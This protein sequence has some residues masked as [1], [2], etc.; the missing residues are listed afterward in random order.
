MSREKQGYVPISE[1]EE[2]KI[3]RLE[4]LESKADRITDLRSRV[5]TFLKS[6]R[7]RLP[8][9]SPEEGKKYGVRMSMDEIMVAVKGGAS[10]EELFGFDESVTGGN[11]PLSFEGFEAFYF[12]GGSE[13]KISEIEEGLGEQNAFIVDFESI[14]NVH[15]ELEGLLLGEEEDEGKEDHV[16]NFYEMRRNELKD[17]S[18][19]RYKLVSYL[20]YLDR[21]LTRA[22]NDKQKF[23]SIRKIR[24]AYRQGA[25][26]L[27]DLLESP[28]GYVAIMGSR[29][30]Q[31]KE[32]FD[33]GGKI[34]ET[35]YV[36][37]MMEKMTAT[38]KTG[39]P[40]FLYG[41]L[42][43]GKT[44]L[45]R[46]LARKTLSEAHVERWKK[47]NPPPSRENK[48][49]SKE[50]R[51]RL[52][53]QHE[54][55]V[56]SGH[57]TSEASE[58]T[59]TRTIEAKEQVSPE[60]QA[61]EIHLRVAAARTE[62]LGELKGKP[63]ETVKEYMEEWDET[64]KPSLIKALETSFNNPIE[65]GER[66][67]M[68]LEAMHDGRPLVIDE[69]NA[70]P[71]HTLI[72]MNDLLTRRPGDEVNV[73]YLKKPFTVAEGFIVIGTG[74]YKP[75]DGLMYKGRQEM[76]AAFLSRFALMGY[77]YLPQRKD[78]HAMSADLPEE[79]QR[80][81]K[82]ENELFQMLVVR[83]ID[84][85]L[86]FEAPPDVFDQLHRLS[87]VA[88]LLQEIFS[89]TDDGKFKFTDPSNAKSAETDPGLI[90]KENVLSLRH[91][92]PIVQRWKE[93]GFRKPLDDYLFDEYVTRSNARPLEK[94]N[95]YRLLQ[96]KSF[97]M[98]FAYG[99]MPWPGSNG[100]DMDKVLTFSLDHSFY[101]RTE[102]DTKVM[103]ASVELEKHRFTA[104]DIIQEIFGN[105]PERTEISKEFIEGLSPA[106]EEDEVSKEMQLR[107]AKKMA[108]AKA[109]GIGFTERTGMKIDRSTLKKLADGE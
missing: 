102:V 75:E 58:L 87:V 84:K 65:T 38:L 86:S 30:R 9:K 37:M 24:D 17:V 94:F 70:I 51:I 93:E 55:L 78:S 90:L 50:W 83:M 26:K 4:D 100:D 91:L 19:K 25:D 63:V 72:L 3:E 33:S 32:S 69:M 77:D 67:G 18:L 45:A 13:E 48:E 61:R 85:D 108:K 60:Q 1:Q 68:L 56:Y 40:I 104:K 49:A 105:I 29:L 109:S 82:S 46:H 76:D 103:D 6:Y 81:Q 54:P 27:T 95:I 42:G 35:P 96:M 101:G 98:D 44:E 34:V 52:K 47:Q 15:E 10:P 21:T 43:S 16:E 7:S 11:D 39:R 71:H 22:I 59:V 66:L 89:G 36:K 53:E 31:M 28:E 80:K 14:S 74:N 5:A 12:S 64:Y 99:D 2:G 88:R 73:P 107:I 57:K 92:I 97:F 20:E 23:D 106:E 79:E 8:R 41:E 62:Q